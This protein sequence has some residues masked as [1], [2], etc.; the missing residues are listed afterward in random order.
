MVSILE[1]LLNEIKRENPQI[2]KAYLCSHEPGCYHNNFLVP[3]IRDAGSRIGIAVERYDFS[4]PQHGK[5]L[6]NRIICPIKNPIRVYCNE[7]HDILTA[8]DM[9]K[10]LM[11]R[12]VCRTTAPVCM[13]NTSNCTLEVNKILNFSTY[14]NFS[15]EQAGLRVWKAYNIGMGKFI[16]YVDIVSKNQG[17]TDLSTIETFF[18]INDRRAFTPKSSALEKNEDNDLYVCTEENCSFSFKTLDELEI[19]V[20]IDCH[21]KPDTDE[22][23]FD[24]LRRD[25]AKRFVTIDKRVVTV[26][27]TASYNDKKSATTLPTGWALQKRAPSRKFPEAVKKYSTWE[28]RQG[29]RLIQ[30]KYL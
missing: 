24:K 2:T 17:P 3:A 11:E 9:R 12:P 4:E 28:K 14:H 6:W 29:G 5:D 13:L 27:S 1:N 21:S 22:G 23:I 20:S 7:G 8:M 10:A 16:P 15:Y 26:Q 19:H 30:R 18:P 25:W